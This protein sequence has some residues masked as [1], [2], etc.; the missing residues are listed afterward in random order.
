MPFLPP[1]VISLMPILYVFSCCAFPL[2]SSF[3]RSAYRFGC[4]ASQSRGSRIASVAF[5]AWSA[6]KSFCVATKSPLYFSSFLKAFLWLFFHFSSGGKLYVF[7][8]ASGIFFSRKTVFC[9]TVFPF[10]SWMEI[11]AAAFLPYA[12]ASMQVST[13]A[14]SACKKVWICVLAI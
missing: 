3:T 12:A 4:S 8:V 2:I 9:A 13:T 10:L 5:A 11:S 14:W 6:E 7:S 1:Y